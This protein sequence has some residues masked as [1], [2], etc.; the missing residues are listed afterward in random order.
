MPA[1]RTINISMVL[2]TTLTLAGCASSPSDVQVGAA[3]PAAARADRTLDEYTPPSP[4][5]ADG[6]HDL[7]A[8]L[9]AYEQQLARNE[10]RL[11]AMGV[12]IAAVEAK[13]MDAVAAAEERFAPPPPSRP[14]DAATAA[15]RAKSAAAPAKKS[16]TRTAPAATPRPVTPVG[17]APASGRAA[18]QAKDDRDEGEDAARCGE[19]C[20]LAHATCDLEAKICELAARHTDEPRYAEVCRRAGDDCHAAAAAC[21]LCSP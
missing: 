3:E 12:R 18:E 9:E 13:T 14:G 8:T 6:I 20:E 15:P 7:E 19:L 16:S 1:P 11:Q 17:G 10:S 4:A 5:A 21:D 2:A